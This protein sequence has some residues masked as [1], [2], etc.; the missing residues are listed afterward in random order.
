MDKD[1]QNGVVR[2]LI[3]HLHLDGPSSD[4]VCQGIEG[5]GEVLQHV[6]GET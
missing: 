1:R 4:I 2:L 5:G 6:A 3:K